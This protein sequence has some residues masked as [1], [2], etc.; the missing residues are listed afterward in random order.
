MVSAFKA[1]QLTRSGHPID[2]T[3]QEAVKGTTIKSTAYT[4]T[5][6]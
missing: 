4:S 3:P 1:G 6:P 2:S 5:T